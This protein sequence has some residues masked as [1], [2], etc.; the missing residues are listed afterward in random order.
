MTVL[1]QNGGIAHINNT[2]ITLE[3][4]NDVH[5]FG[6]IISKFMLGYVSNRFEHKDGGSL[7]LLL[8]LRNIQINNNRFANVDDED[9]NQAAIEGE[10]EEDGEGSESTEFI[11]DEETLDDLNAVLDDCM[12]R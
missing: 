9:P 4:M 5:Y 1:D 3:H 11:G 8:L 6:V 7:P 2:M 12:L 10:E